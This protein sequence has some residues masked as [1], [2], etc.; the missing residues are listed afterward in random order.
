MLQYSK[1]YGRIKISY[2]ATILIKKSIRQTIASVT[3]FC[4][5]EWFID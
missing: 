5:N 1:N 3:R 4:L 2:Y